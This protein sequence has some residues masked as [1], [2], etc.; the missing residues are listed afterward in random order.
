[1]E[2]YEIVE[3][4]S[5][6]LLLFVLLPRGTYLL[7]EAKVPQ[8]PKPITVHKVSVFNPRRQREKRRVAFSPDL[9]ID[10]PHAPLER[11]LIEVRHI[12]R[13]Q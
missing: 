8:L 11:F 9:D 10:L 3:F 13:D 7:I 12:L 5:F 1:M 2:G 6:T 4:G